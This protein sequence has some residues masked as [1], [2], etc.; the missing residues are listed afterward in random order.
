MSLKEAIGLI[1]DGDH[2]AAGGCHYS[3]TPMAAVWEIIRQKEKKPGLLP[4]HQFDRRR[5]ST[6]GPGRPA[7]GWPAGSAR[8]SPGGS[9]G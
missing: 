1:K 5:S 3:R 9:R 8:E 4:V 6:G 2:V 7:R